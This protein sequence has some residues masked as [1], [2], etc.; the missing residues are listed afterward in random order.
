MTITCEKIPKIKVL[1]C[2]LETG[3]LRNKFAVWL[4]KNDELKTEICSK[5]TNE[6]ILEAMNC[7][8]YQF[9]EVKW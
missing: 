2:L 9:F 8:F 3:P 6:E 4:D 5:M 1:D 7:E